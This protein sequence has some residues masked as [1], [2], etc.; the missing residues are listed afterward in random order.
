MVVYIQG[1]LYGYTEQITLTK[2]YDQDDS[3]NYS[4]HWPTGLG[5]K[6]KSKSNQIVDP[7]N[8]QR[9]AGESKSAY[10]FS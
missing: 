3:G 8:Q 6:I 9:V 7:K 1:P 10:L 2:S 4:F 5:L